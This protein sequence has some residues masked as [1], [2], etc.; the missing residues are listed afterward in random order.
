MQAFP[1]LGMPL[2]ALGELHEHPIG[3]RQGRRVF[4]CTADA[5]L[6]YETSSVELS[7]D[8]TEHYGESVFICYA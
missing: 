2:P 7:K 4:L 3:V 1:Q 8:F 5:A 6:K